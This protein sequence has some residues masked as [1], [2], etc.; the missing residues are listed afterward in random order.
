MTWPLAPPIP[1]LAMD[2]NERPVPDREPKGV[3][4]RATLRRCLSHWIL[5]LGSTRFTFGGIV[6]LSKIRHTFTNDA[7]N[8]VDSR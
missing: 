3:G 2:T 6:F 1:E 7:R 8:A 4:S 5:G